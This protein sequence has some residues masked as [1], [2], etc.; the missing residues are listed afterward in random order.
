MLRSNLVLIFFAII[1]SA[2]QTDHFVNITSIGS[3]N[4]PEIR[5]E[6]KFTNIPIIL[7]DSS[8]NSGSFFFE[9]SKGKT[10]L[11]GQPDKIS[12]AADQF[13]ASWQSEGH[14]VTLKINRTPQRYDFSFEAQPDSD[15]LK[16]GIN[17]AA[18]DT[19][20]FTGLLERTVDGNQK[21]SWKEGIQTGMDLHGQ[22]VDMIIKPT[23]SLY[24]PFYLSSAGYGL[25]IKGTWPVSGNLCH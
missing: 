18:A 21:E 13:E 11:T 1:L 6:N 16:W 20:Y 24:S 22:E 25:F 15:I 9:T 2:C 17:I 8:G 14:T 19:E 23:L 7:G 12:R 5:I 4:F 10:W 3:K